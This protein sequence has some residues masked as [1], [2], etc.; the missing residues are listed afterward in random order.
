MFFYTVEKLTTRNIIAFGHAKLENFT[1][2][3]NWLYVKD[4]FVDEIS[5]S[6]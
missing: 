2:N 3:A 5:V 1:K 4:C 6:I